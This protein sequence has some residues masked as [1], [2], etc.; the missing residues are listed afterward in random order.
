MLL[1]VAVQLDRG[2]QRHPCLNTPRGRG[3][4]TGD[5]NVPKF[6]EVASLLQEANWLAER[7]CDMAFKRREWRSEQDFA[8]IQ[9]PKH[10]KNAFR[11]ALERGWLKGQSGSGKCQEKNYSNLFPC[12]VVDLY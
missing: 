5:I 12:N 4:Q 11:F 1:N 6:A 9:S 7:V 10:P 2:S 3:K 8:C